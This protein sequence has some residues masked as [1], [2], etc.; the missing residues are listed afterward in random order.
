MS[1]KTT[2]VAL[3]S[4][5]PQY[6]RAIMEGQKL[7]EFRKKKFSKDIHY[8]LVYETAPRKSVVGYFTVNKIDVGTPQDL[9][10]RHASIGKISKDDYFAYYR[11]CEMFS[12]ILRF[13]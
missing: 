4:I 2:D 3:M 10:E 12:V 13:L 7:V 6:V 5:N 9:W 8:V 1:T 11:A